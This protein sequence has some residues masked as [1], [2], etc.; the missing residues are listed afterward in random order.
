MFIN[1]IV[2]ASFV[3]QVLGYN[4]WHAPCNR[5]RSTPLSSSFTF[6]VPIPFVGGPSSVLPSKVPSI[7]SRIVASSSTIETFPTLHA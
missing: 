1:N 7:L 2:A 4:D 3:E 6:V 5:T